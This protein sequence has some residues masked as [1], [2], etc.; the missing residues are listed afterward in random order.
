MFIDQIKGDKEHTFDLAYHQAGAWKTLPRGKTWNLV[1]NP[2]KQSVR[3]SLPDGSEWRV[4]S[5]FA[6]K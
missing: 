1:A 6:V 2:Q 5:A 3:V 4:N